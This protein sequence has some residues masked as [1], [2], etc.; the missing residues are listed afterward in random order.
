MNEIEFDSLDFNNVD[1]KDS[2]QEPGKGVDYKTPT[3]KA[4]QDK[5]RKPPSPQWAYAI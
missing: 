2:N 5:K 1:F 4:K 3:T